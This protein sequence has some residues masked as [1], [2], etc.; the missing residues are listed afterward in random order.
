MSFVIAASGLQ[1]FVATDGTTALGS[2]Q[3]KDQPRNKSFQKVV[4]DHTE[5]SMKS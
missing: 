4:I 1:L 5:K 3:V 2:H